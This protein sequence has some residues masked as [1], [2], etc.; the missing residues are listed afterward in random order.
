MKNSTSDLF[1]ILIC[2]GLIAGY[3]AYKTKQKI[4]N[5]TSD[6]FDIF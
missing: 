3:I 4:N 5:A 1:V 2:G 6:I